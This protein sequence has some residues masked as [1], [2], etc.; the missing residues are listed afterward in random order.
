MPAKNT[1]EYHAAYKAKERQSYMDIGPIP[2][3][4]NPERRA[5]CE[6]DF[7]KFCS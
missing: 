2:E 5:S 4:K 6:N 7:H 1:R 3:V